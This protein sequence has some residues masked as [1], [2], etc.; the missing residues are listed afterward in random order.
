MAKGQ[1]PTLLNQVTCPMVFSWHKACFLKTDNLE[2]DF[3]QHQVMAKIA[4]IPP[5]IAVGHH[6]WGS[7]LTR[8]S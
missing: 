4:V 7:H 3:A 2:D 1:M 6:P 8:S 5:L